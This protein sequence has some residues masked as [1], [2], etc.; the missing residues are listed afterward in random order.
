MSISLLIGCSDFVYLVGKKVS[1]FSLTGRGMLITYWICAAM[2]FEGITITERHSRHQLKSSQ[3]I[4]CHTED[5][6]KLAFK[7]LSIHSFWELS[8]LG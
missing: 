3:C 8:R 5:P 2:L 6:G 1:R 7:P 4:L